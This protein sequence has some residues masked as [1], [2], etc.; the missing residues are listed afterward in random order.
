MTELKA[1]MTKVEEKLKGMDEYKEA[2]IVASQPKLTTIMSSALHDSLVKSGKLKLDLKL[3]SF[4]HGISASG[5]FWVEPIEDPTKTFPAA[6]AGEKKVV[7]PYFDKLL[8]QFTANVKDSGFEYYSQSNGKFTMKFVSSHKVYCL[9]TGK[10][11]NIPTVGTRK[12]DIVAQYPGLEGVLGFTMIGELKPRG[13]GNFSADEIGQLLDTNFELMRQQP[14]RQF[15]FTFIS[16]GVRFT[17]FRVLRRDH[18]NFEVTYT[19]TYS[20]L[21]RIHGMIFFFC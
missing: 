10:Y 6:N 4:F 15:A 17:F 18:D 9:P 2:L 8:D 16:D 20:G 14:L 13:T 21:G 12:P 19:P 7:Q 5:N 3:A 11:C 1:K